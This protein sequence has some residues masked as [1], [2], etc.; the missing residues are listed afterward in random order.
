MVR[1][2][3]RIFCSLQLKLFFFCGGRIVVLIVVP[4]TLFLLSQL[5]LL[6]CRKGWGLSKKHLWNPWRILVKALRLI[7]LFLLKKINTQIWE[8][9]IFRKL[10]IQKLSFSS[11]ELPVMPL[12]FLTN[13]SGTVPKNRRIKYKLLLPQIRRESHRIKYRIF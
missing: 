8:V 4:V 5:F 1:V 9:H 11:E 12:L 2:S 13:R 3:N 7:F 10:N 6:L